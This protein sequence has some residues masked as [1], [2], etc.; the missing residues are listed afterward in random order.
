VVV[1]S[2]S[3]TSPPSVASST[4]ERPAPQAVVGQ[5]WNSLV[6]MVEGQPPLLLLLLPLLL[7]PL[8]LLPLEAGVQPHCQKPPW[9]VS[10]GL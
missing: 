10:L 7:L 2:Y 6:S 5:V 3:H 8:L 9:H 1:Q 4:Q